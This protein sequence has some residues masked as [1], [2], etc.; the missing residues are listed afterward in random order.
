MIKSRFC[1]TVGCI[2]SSEN[3]KIEFKTLFNGYFV[4]SGSRFLVSAFVKTPKINSNRTFIEIDWT[5]SFILNEKLS[6]YE[7]LIDNKTVYKGVNTTVLKASNCTS[8]YSV[9]NDDIN[10]GLTIFNVVL[11]AF[12]QLHSL[13]SPNMRIISNCSGKKLV[14]INGT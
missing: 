2:W 5:D 11:R 4:L 13:E 9:E 10:G 12:T 3:D 14:V 6:Y 1:S 7:L 8:N